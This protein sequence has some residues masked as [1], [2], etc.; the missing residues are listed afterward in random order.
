MSQRHP[1]ALSAGLVSL[2]CLLTPARAQV[3]LEINREVW[4]QKFGV[5]DAQM[6][7]I[8]PY[9]G[10]L[11]QDA[12]GDGVPNGQEFTAGTSPFKL[13]PSE[14][15]FVPPAVTMNP[16]SLTLGFPTVPGKLYSAVASDTLV[17][18]WAGG[19]ATVTGDGSVKSLTVPKDA[20]K[21]F[22]LSVTDQASQGD[23]VS[24]WAK[25]VLGLSTSAPVGSQTSFD[26]TSLSAE[27]QTQ[28]VVTL[29]TLDFAAIQPGDAVTAASDLAVVRV[30]RSGF[31]LL[32][33]LTIPISRSGTAE[34]GT[35][36]AP[37]PAT[38]TFPPGVKSLDLKIVPLFNPARTS[39]ATVILAAD[40]PGSAGAA[41]HYSNGSPA[42]AGVTVYPSGNPSGTGLRGDYYRGASSTY[43]SA[44]NFGGQSAN[45]SFTRTAANS[46]IATITYTG[47]PAVPFAIGSSR[48]LQFTSQS[49]STNFGSPLPYTIGS[50]PTG[51]SFTVTVTGSVPGTVGGSAITGTV[52]VGAF[53]APTTRIDPTVDFFWSTI[54]EPSMPADNFTVRWT[55]QILPQYSQKY[56]FVTRSDDGVRL[57][58]NNQQILVRWPGGGPTDTT[59]SIDLQAGVR[60]D[61]KLEYYEATSS[62]EARLYWY[63]EDQAKQIIP[64]N[65][66]FPT[67]SGTTPLAGNP[68]AGAPSITSP[69]QPV[70][71]LGSGS[72]FSLI[73]MGSNGGTFTASGLPGWLTLVNGVLTGTPPAAGVYQF[74]VTTTN[75][76]GTS[77]AVVTL[78]V[79]AAQNQLTRDLW[80][81]GVTGPGI[82]D[83][84]WNSPPTST[85]TVSNVEDQTTTYAAN[86]GE[87]LRGYFL[88]PVTGNYY[89]WVASSN[90]AELWI[91]NNA[92]AVNKVRR[93]FV[94]GPT[95]SGQ[96]VWNTQ[97][98]QK[99]QWLSLVAGQKYYL[100][101]R[102]NTGNGGAGNHLSV[103]WFLDPTGTTAA[104]IANG[105]PPAPATTGGVIP[106]HAISPWDNPP[107]TTVPGTLYVTN[108]Q[109]VAG[110]GNITA[111]GGAFLRV[112]GSTAVLQLNYSGLSS[113]AISRKLHNSSGQVV[114][115]I[116]AQEKNYPT[117]GT[118]DGGHTWAMQAADLADLNNGGVYLRIATINYPD[119]EISGTFGK[120][121][122]SQTAPAVPA[123]PSWSDLH[124]TSDAANSRFLSQATFGPSPS[125][126]AEVKANGYRPWIENQFGT[127]STRNLPF[128][129]ANL[130]NDPQNNY[131]SS[132]M[133]NSWW[134][135]SVTAPDQLR[136][137]AAFALSEILVISDTGPLNN[138]GRTLADYYDTL[139][140]SAFGNF[141]DILK[142]VTLSSAMGVYLDMRGNSA[143]NIVTGQIPNENY[144]R[145]ILQ[146]F[147]AGLYRV[148]P[149]GTLVLD[150]TGGAVATYDQAVITGM[151]RVFT[152]WTWGQKLLAGDRLPT[153]FGPSSNFLDPMV[154]VANKHEL[155]S[156]IL[157]DNVVLP[158]A[159]VTS[160]GDTSTDPTSTYYV[161]STDPLLGPGFLVNTLVT[162]RYDLNGVRDL[163]VTLDNIFANS[164]TGPYICRQL[165]QRLVTSHPKP[166]Y[167]HRVVRAFNG[168][169]NVDGVATGIRGDMKE[170]FRAILLDPEARSSTAAADPKFGK[171]REPVLRITGP[172]RAF[173]STGF[174]G[175]TYRQHI[176]S[177]IVVTT[178]QPHRLSNETIRLENFTDGGAA[179]TNLPTAQSY[180]AASVTPSYSL[181]GATG[182][183]TINAP[184]YAAGDTVSLQFTS[185]ALG[186]T[187]PYNQPQNYVVQSAAP[188][189]FTIN[190]GN[191]TFANINSG[192]SITPNNFT[193]SNNTVSSGNY[194]VSGTTVT[195]INSNFDPGDQLFLSF[196]T[197][198][199]AAG[200]QSG[201]Y[202]VTA[203]TA[204]S[205]TVSLAAPPADSTGGA[206]LIPR[207]TGG[208]NVTTTAGVSTIHLQTGGNHNLVDGE[209]VY[210]KIITGNQGTPALS[211]IYTVALVTGP[212]SFRVTSPG[213]ISNGS[214]GTSGQAVLPRKASHWN[215]NGTVTVNLSTWNVGLTQNELN[216]T[217]LNAATVFN[218]FYPDYQY[219]GALAQAGLTTPEFQ[220][221][222][223]SSTMNLTNAISASILSSGNPNGYT[224]FKSGGGAVTMDLATYMTPAQTSN[225]GIPGLVDAL[226]T[227]LTGGNLTVTTK[228][229]IVNYV[230]SNHPY[231]TP[232]SVQMRDRVRA[233]IQLIVTSAEY[234]I[235]K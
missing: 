154:L 165:I 185:A 7:Q 143:G 83:V 9:I 173:P 120:I 64:A 183:A 234:A 230:T 129:L 57:W 34:A 12:D 161:Q 66:L 218:F 45:Y 14:P 1:C 27:L 118:S 65:R 206:C 169:R 5:L 220:F 96:R 172:A 203:D 150:S 177:T 88:A 102:H 28:N 125:D 207:L 217:P 31:M 71:I 163:E 124:A 145:E 192:T 205:F 10:W 235:Q 138:N 46:G 148:W 116:G 3:D 13:L 214:Q 209:S 210:I 26:A 77:S 44:L 60:Y 198:G 117:L 178:P 131:G 18:T 105:S 107:T 8:P 92:E 103:A 156:K 40:A 21:F 109:G 81:S 122:G 41:G 100:E 97:P 63:G 231:T 208:Y 130:S 37:I 222:N 56:Y 155:G 32:G 54:P 113:G 232:T 78:Q 22:R 194:T 223:D 6:D 58:V 144:A 119:G 15:R 127:P 24:D 48:I 29:V 229:T 55:G 226:G 216:Q 110:L 39:G 190:I 82:G 134:R 175:S 219:P 191:T 70:Y 108:L 36:Y 196:T 153:N 4:K 11:A 38:V 91:S 162:N 52:T 90:A 111:T 221:T 225:A 94:T 95:G 201:V 49:M 50:L 147:S 85:S 137:R 69:T 126:M 200:G 121:A 74:T 179:T 89:F 79:L 47:S 132:L 146:L 142:Q 176:G 42:F 158:A 149:D 19:M 98:N 180:A 84:P 166:D 139:L 202:T 168:E 30:T 86:T 75:A 136:Q 73:L 195:V 76:S 188:T 186:L 80:T 53:H 164:A 33:A 133:F 224:S 228:N 43:A 115:D 160:Q 20:G 227:L 141:R 67:I 123:Y 211:G 199:L 157:L 61:I 170:V 2:L 25:H 87:R 23:E 233:I 104:P 101:A 99:S 140:D 35:D 212:N 128:I 62:A 215:R 213:V 174:T 182:L 187:A 17:G 159:T 184:G 68:F 171:Q 93:A 135:N 167:V 151:A 114:F 72:P 59:G 189:V 197:G 112:S 106:G 193:V 16:T 152:G 51:T 204:S 181:V